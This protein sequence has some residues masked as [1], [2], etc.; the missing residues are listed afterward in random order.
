[1]EKRINHEVKEPIDLFYFLLNTYS[2]S[3][4]ETLLRLLDNH[5]DIER[6]RGLPQQELAEI[7]CDAMATSMWAQ[8]FGT[9]G[10]PQAA[11]QAV[12]ATRPSA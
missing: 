7:Y 2:Q 10:K 5:P 4:K 11:G 12:D 8:G 3:S 9:Q 1:M 6:L